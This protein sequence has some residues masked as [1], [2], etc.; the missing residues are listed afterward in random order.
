MS[1]IG[2]SNA[3]KNS[4]KVSS[5][6]SLYFFGGI[7]VCLFSVCLIMNVWY[8]ARVFT[9]IPAYLFGMGSYAIYLF[10]YT[11]GM[12]L[13]FREKGVHFKKKL[14]IV[15]MILLFVAICVGLSLGYNGGAISQDKFNHF[16]Q[17]AKNFG[18]YLGSGKGDTILGFD[19]R[20]PLAFY[21][22]VFFKLEPIK[23]SNPV[24]VKYAGGLLG[25]GIAALFG[26][27]GNAGTALGWA[28][29]IIFGLLGIFLMFKD[30]II[31]F[32]KTS[33]P[34]KGSKK[35]EEGA[36]TG[37]EPIGQP[38]PYAQ[39]QQFSGNPYEQAPVSASP[40]R[41]AAP[42]PINQPDF[43]KP[44]EKRQTIMSQAVPLAG[45]GY[46]DV[47]V[48]KP[49]RFILEGARN[50]QAASTPTHTA[51]VAQ[52]EPVERKVEQT[53]LDF[54][55]KPSLDEDLVRAKPIF[56]EPIPVAQSTPVIETV[57][58]VES[59]VVNV[60]PAPV[61]EQP[62]AQQQTMQAGQIQVKKPIKWV[63]PSS[64]NLVSVETSEAM[65]LNQRVAEERMQ[66]I[67]NIFQ[68]FQIGASVESYTIGPAV[69]RYNIRY[70]ANVSNKSVERI[71]DDISIRLGG[72]NAR[73]ESVVE[74]QYTSG[75]EIPNA[76]I[77]TVS[78]K[79]IYEKL[80]DVKKHPLAVAFGKNING[81]VIWADFNEFPHA[82]VAGTTGSGKSVFVNSVITSLIMRNSPD[83]LRLVLIDPKKV[84]MSK[85]KDMPHLLCPVVNEANEAK[86]VMS[87]LVDEMNER[88]AAFESA[89]GCTSLKEYNEYAEEKG[90]EKLPYIIVFLDEYADLVDSCKEIS[91]PVVVIGQKARAC[92]IH[93]LIATQR[94]STNVI[95]GTIKGNLPTH[96]A[97]MTAST[98]D[99]CTIVGEGGAEK[100]LGKGDMLVQS[101][102]VSRVGMVRLQSCFIQ[103]KDMLYV[104]NY[105][106]EHYETRYNEKFLNLE[107][108]S[109]E[110]GMAM[111]ASGE[112]EAS[113]DPAEEAR[114]QDIKNWVMTQA[115]MSMSRI[116]RD[117]SVGFNRAG[118]F[119]NRLQ[120]EGIVSTE[121]EANRGCRVIASLDSSN[122]LSDLPCS[123]EL[124]R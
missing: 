86:L 22:D 104:V 5:I 10:I 101:P 118:R 78:F 42:A 27:A 23:E 117:C 95:T 20:K 55:E 108:A 47:G 94:P 66:A 29:T 54:T 85:Y 38:Q 7:F 107:E 60:A 44:V 36:S 103:R 57:K 87:K 31:T 71:V 46:A 113:M 34:N 83:D 39:P 19:P 80:P 93:L 102:L 9:F 12:S 82:L 123:D 91:N 43:T 89:E 79:E 96:I 119:F 40:R 69:T 68:D 49:A 56:E 122:D 116:Q 98:V 51:P 81:D 48:F 32:V 74:G 33:F 30:Q 63:A 8:V 21:K 6:K 37:F 59:T 105:L 112:V 111:V 106:K 109:R 124:I 100:L 18:L 97:L 75:L 24:A 61:M 92:G 88:Y 115:Y 11:I 65:G 26:K 90:L 58:P 114:Y 121:T 72:V 84:E 77:T 17:Y 67:N 16:N 52:P 2:E 4:K 50:S 3:A 1:T 13:L 15:G 110:A 73:F 76:T 14:T 70:E 64:E 25:N 99:S 28:V 120:K 53:Y 45:S 41:E 62:A 35:V